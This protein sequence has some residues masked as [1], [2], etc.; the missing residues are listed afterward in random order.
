MRYSNLIS[1]QS[2]LSII[3]AHC[4]SKDILCKNLQPLAGNPLLT[5]NIEQV[6]QSNLVQ[7]VVVSTDGTEIG[8]VVQQYGAEVIWRPAEISGDWASSE[9]SWKLA[10]CT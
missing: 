7:S 2:I 3:P 8:A 4:S 5:Y 6:L 10:L 9:S 1:K